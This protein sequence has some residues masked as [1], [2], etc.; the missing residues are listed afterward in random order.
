MK[1]ALKKSKKQKFI[2]QINLDD[3]GL[4]GSNERDSDEDDS[5]SDSDNDWDNEVLTISNAQPLWTLPLY[6]LLP[7][8][9]QQKVR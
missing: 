1:K 3:F 9:K 8:H 2:P 7:S 4:P 6:S 5:G